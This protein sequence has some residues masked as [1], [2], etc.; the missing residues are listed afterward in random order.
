[1][2]EIICPV[3]GKKGTLHI[4][5]VKNNYGV[6]YTYYYVAHYDGVRGKTRKL[7]WHYIGK[8]LP[9]QK[10]KSESQKHKTQSAVKDKG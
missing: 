8:E 7:K 2:T 3:C 10:N 1:M 5:E 4:K 9:E 6:V